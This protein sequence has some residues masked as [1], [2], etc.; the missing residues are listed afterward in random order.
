MKNLKASDLKPFTKADQLFDRLQATQE[1]SSIVPPE[2][3]ADIEV[4]EVLAKVSPEVREKII[5]GLPF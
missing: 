2:V 4:R 3:M 5:R 1:F